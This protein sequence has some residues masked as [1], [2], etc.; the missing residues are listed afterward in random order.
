MIMVGDKCI[1]VAQENFTSLLAWVSNIWVCAKEKISAA[2]TNRDAH[3][4]KKA[5]QSDVRDVSLAVSLD[6]MHVARRTLNT[7]DLH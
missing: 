2:G 7:V 5:I 4:I 6:M 3:E 1:V